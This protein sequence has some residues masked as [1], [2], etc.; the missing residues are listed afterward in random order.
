MP[1]QVISLLFSSEMPPKW[2]PWMLLSLL[3]TLAYFAK[4]LH[5]LYFSESQTLG[6][7]LSCYTIIPE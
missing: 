7:K 5:F 1:E 2:T 4:I 3:K 6:A